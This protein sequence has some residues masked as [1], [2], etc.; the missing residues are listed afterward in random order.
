MK[1]LDKLNLKDK[2][3]IIFDL[4]GTLIDS[5]GVWNMTDQKLIQDYSGTIVDLDTVQIDRDNFLHNNTGSDIYIAYC[6]YLIDKY[7]LSITDPNELSDIRKDVAN[8]V[9]KND[10]GFK[11][12]V[13]ELI[14]RLKKLGYIIALA[15]ITTES[16]LEIY[17]KENQKM[18]SEMNIQETFDLITTKET[19]K[20]KKPYPEV[21]LKIMEHFG[22]E[23][24]ECLI[25]EDSYAGTLAGKNAGIEVVSIYDKYADVERDKINDIMDYFIPDYRTFIDG[26]VKKQFRLLSSADDCHELAKELLR[27]LYPGID[28]WTA[29]YLDTPMGSYTSK[30]RINNGERSRDT[31]SP[32]FT[33]KFAK[34]EFLRIT[35]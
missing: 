6:Q 5:I 24:S 20:N 8:E 12:D 11:P 25:F 18:L 13:V 7:G 10:I 35:V 32:H 29:T 22:V 30:Y 15:T 3:V 16:Q 4:D 19:V 9:L 2:K 31:H 34:D 33:Y 17:Y 21:Y 28:F 14:T 1:N 23:P 27:E 26:C